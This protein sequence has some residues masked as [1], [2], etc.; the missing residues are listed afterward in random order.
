[1]YH[2][3]SRALR[4]ADWLDA[5]R[6]RAWA[7]VFAAVLVLRVCGMIVLSGRDDVPA[8]DFVCFW[9]AATLAAGGHAASVY[10]GPALSALEHATIAIPANAAYG[11]FYPPTFLLLLLPL[12]AL[13]YITGLLAFLA[14]TWVPFAACMRQIL[15][16]R[17]AL[18]PI[19]VFPGAV[20]SAGSGQNGLLSA[21]CIGGYMVLLDRRPVLAG[22]CLGVLSYKPHLAVCAPVALLCARRWRAL[23]GAA[24]SALTLAAASLLVFGWGAWAGFMHGLPSAGEMLVHALAEPAKLQST[25]GAFRLHRALTAGLVAQAAVSTAGLVLL[26]LGTWR[27]PG[28]QAEGALLAAAALICSPYLV[29]YDLA[30][31]GLPLAWLMAEAVH[32]TFRPWE[33]VFLLTAY[34]LPILSYGLA[35]SSGISVAPFVLSALMLAVLTRVRAS[36]PKLAGRKQAVLS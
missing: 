22:L 34:I 20:V 13:P 8:E 7:R 26:A 21:S 28:G 9:A 29:D 24:A 14:A 32:T 10:Q 5:G 2:L 27:R 17:W 36:A 19:A 25:F 3:L 31:L 1:M 30:V 15:P 18:L 35:R 16:Q 12:A 33:K 11:F 23:M 4:D 6:A